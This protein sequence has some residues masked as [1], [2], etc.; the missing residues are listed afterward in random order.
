MRRP[1]RAAVCFT[2]FAALQLSLQPPASAWCGG[3]DGRGTD[4]CCR[5]VEPAE[6]AGHGCCDDRAETPPVDETVKNDGGCHC[7][8]VPND[9]PAIPP[10]TP[11]LFDAE[12]QFFGHA[13]L[14]GWTQGVDP[15]RR[16]DSIA[17]ARAPGARRPLRVLIQVFR[18]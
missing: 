9:V 14:P 15:P 18:L 17:L 1:N 7:V 16:G 10:K 13:E 2:L 3:R 4:C 5:V 8:A 11:A 6:D 12:L